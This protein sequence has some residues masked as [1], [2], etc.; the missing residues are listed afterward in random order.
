[1]VEQVALEKM[2]RN[3]YKATV[4]WSHVNSE[5]A[6]V[7]ISKLEDN[8][9]LFVNEALQYF[10]CQKSE[11]ILAR[12]SGKLKILY[13]LESA[14]IEQFD[15]SPKS[16]SNGL[17]SRSIMRKYI[18]ALLLLGCDVSKCRI[19]K[20]CNDFRVIN[21]TKFAPNGTSI[22]AD[23]TDKMLSVYENDDI[24]AYIRLK[25]KNVNL[26]RFEA[27]LKLLRCDVLSDVDE[28]HEKAIIRRIENFL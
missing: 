12:V 25:F 9:P 26:F 17:R 13:K 4:K 22:M 15:Y 11:V 6:F 5:V 8:Y 7:T 16:V 10:G 28:R 18:M 27:K 24:E 14:V 3:I 2:D 21:I 1:M 19:I 20:Y 23:L